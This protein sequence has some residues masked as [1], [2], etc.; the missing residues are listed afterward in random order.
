MAKGKKISFQNWKFIGCSGYGVSHA[1]LAVYNTCPC[2]ARTHTP[3]RSY[4]HEGHEGVYGHIVN[5]NAGYLLVQ[6][7]DLH[8]HCDR[9]DICVVRYI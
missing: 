9:D 6:L 7:I 4:G 8:A 3:I 1:R 2:E 5:I